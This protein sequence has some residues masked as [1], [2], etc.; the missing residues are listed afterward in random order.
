MESDVDGQ[1]D[2]FSCSS[3]C[4]KE[5][6]LGIQVGGFVPDFEEDEH[7]V[8]DGSCFDSRCTFLALEFC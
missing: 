7:S 5:D 8:T 3:I 1:F 4:L 6:E 2:W